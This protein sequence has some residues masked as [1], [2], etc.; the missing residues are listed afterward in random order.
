MVAGGRKPLR[1]D[2]EVEVEVEAEEE[3][4]KIGSVWRSRTNLR[5]NA[6]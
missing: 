4:A 2:D 1:H 6:S 3:E 5:T